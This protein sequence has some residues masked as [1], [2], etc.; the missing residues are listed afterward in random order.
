MTDPLDPV[1]AF[2]GGPSTA[3]P[4]DT[5]KRLQLA[6]ASPLTPDQSVE[7][8]MG[9]PSTAK[10]GDTRKRL[11]LAGA[12]PLTGRAAQEASQFQGAFDDATAADADAAK[13]KMWGQFN[14]D[15]KNM[16]PADLV[17]K[18]A[19]LHDQL[20]LSNDTGSAQVTPAP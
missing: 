17:R 5:R 1:E 12:V 19:P 6:G 8:I 13:Q 9:G 20:P 11:Q 16:D 2:M 4:G 7:A 18:Y 14:D 15:A 10:P 3:K